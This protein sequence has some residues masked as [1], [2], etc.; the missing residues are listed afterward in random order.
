MIAFIGYVF[1]MAII[2][3]AIHKARQKNMSKDTT[4]SEAFRKRRQSQNNFSP[5]N[6][7][8]TQKRPERVNIKSL[9]TM[10]EDRDNDWLAQQLRS[11]QKSQR[12]VSDMFQ[13][14]QEHFSNCEAE[15][16]HTRH[17]DA[18]NAEQARQSTQK[19]SQAEMNALKQRIQN[20]LGGR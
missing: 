6:T 13:L 8:Y 10:L 4:N 16:I 17:V 20:G 11:E 7:Y 12:V 14:R 2:F 5:N 1:W 15:E 19:M 3:F 9:G 18:C